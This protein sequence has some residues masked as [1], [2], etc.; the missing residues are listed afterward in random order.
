MAK[1]AKNDGKPAVTRA[2]EK[3]ESADRLVRRVQADRAYEILGDPAERVT[4]GLKIGDR[5]NSVWDE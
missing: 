2:P 1:H 3:E 4:L 5:R